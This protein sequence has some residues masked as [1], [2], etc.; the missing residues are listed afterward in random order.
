ML[1]NY[2]CIRIPSDDWQ[3][4]VSSIHNQNRYLEQICEKE[5]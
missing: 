4:E 5:I 2:S 3:V 1:L